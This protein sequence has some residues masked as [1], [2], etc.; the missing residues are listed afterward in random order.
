MVSRD[1]EAKTWGRY[2]LR[3]LDQGKMEGIPVPL[4]RITTCGMVTIDVL[5]QVEHGDPPRGRYTVIPTQT[6]HGRGAVPALTLLKLLA[7][8]P[9]R[10]ATSD[11]L[12]EQMR[13]EM[14]AGALVR[15]DTI[16]SY[17]RGLLCGIT[18]DQQ[19]IDALRVLLVRYLRNGRGS[20]PGYQ[21]APSPVVWLDTDA[22]A[23]HVEH[24]ALME[25]MG[26]PTLA[27]PFWERAYQLASRGVYLPDE[28]SSEWA[29]AMREQVDGA[30]RQ[31][32]HAR[33][34]LSLAEHGEVG[35][36]EA[37]LLLRTYWQS[38]KI[39]EDALRPLLELL[40]KHERFGEAEAYYQQCVVALESVESGKQP[41]T[42]TQ[43]IHE[44]LRVKQL[45][46]AQT[47]ASATLL[48]E[49]RIN[50]FSDFSLPPLAHMIQS[51]KVLQTDLPE[52]V[53]SEHA[54]YRPSER[55]VLVPAPQSMHIPL[56]D[57]TYGD[58][59]AWFSERLALIIALITQWRH[60]MGLITFQKILD[61]ELRVFDE[62]KMMF[63]PE[64]YFLSRRSA[65]LVIAALP[66]GLLGLLQQQKTAFIEE[67]FLPSCA[68]SLTACWYLLN[69]RE[70]ASV[71]RAL[72][73]YM[74]FLVGWARRASTYQRTA[75]YLASQAC[76]LLGFIELHRLQFQQRIVYC[77]EAVKH[78]REAG[79][80]PLLVKAL[81][82]LG[83]AYYDQGLHE[84]ML[85]VY[86]EAERFMKGVP[87]SLQSKVLMGLAHAYAQQGHAAKVLDTISEARGIFPG[88]IEDVPAFLSADDGEYSLILFEGWVRLD[89][90]KC[91]PD[92]DYNE[93]AA[94]ALAQ[95]DS[96]PITR[97]VPER[98]RHEIIN[99]RAQAAIASGELD[100]FR[101]FT[102]Q[103]AE[104]LQVM[105]S[106]KRRQELVIN[107][108]TALKKWPHES[109]V[110]E[111]ADVAL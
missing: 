56:A 72:S 17:L 23:F 64:T 107:Y 48:Q 14:E 105:H 50:D 38:H 59:A 51:H 68:A 87:R 21:L 62:T 1:V 20:G 8:R 75:A 92:K 60:Q 47:P 90:G 34:R 94:K 108:K 45:R 89:L 111:L 13:G 25:R 85:Q 9:H 93:Q 40:G 15:L 71:E 16:A 37:I 52:L 49:V 54:S 39:D 104:I 53:M 46:R 19:Q 42:R 44:F 66:K 6:L 78:G 109:K 96:L 106:E 10:F 74:P 86:Q 43:D 103:S 70:F 65:L 26:E 2:P 31:S 55:R 82:Q 110:V 77:R 27:L 99:R 80:H 98:Y 29:Q 67:E 11:W 28:P 35:E 12:S 57:E 30:L 88:E 33:A 3:F 97:L 32:V 7:G 79:E 95:I 36:E 100:T 81:T 84:E 24:G 63:D 91:Y 102:I 69:G 22:L 18:T 76:L 83:N 41:D 61:R 73:R 4:A 58:C 5:T 101:D